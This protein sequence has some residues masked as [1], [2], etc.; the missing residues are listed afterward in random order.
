MKQHRL[1]LPIVI[2]VEQWIGNT[3]TAMVSLDI[4]SLCTAA[5]D[6]FLL[7]SPVSNSL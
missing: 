4:V 1:L 2:A 3:M 7:E 6:A 5:G